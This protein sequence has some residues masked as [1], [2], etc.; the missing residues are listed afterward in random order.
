MR[1]P[2]PPPTDTLSG[3]AAIAPQTSHIPSLL[4]AWAA[5]LLA[6]DL[7]SIIGSLAGFDPPS[8][9]ALARAAAIGILALAIPRTSRLLHARGFIFALAALA[10]GGWAVAAVQQNVAWFA[11][12]PRA[13]AMFARL[14]L[15]LIPTALVAL[16]LIR[17]G[18]SRRD[19]FL[20]RG[21]LRAPTALPLIRGARWSLL[22]PALLLVVSAGLITQLWIVSHASRHLHP[23]A[24]LWALPS[25]LLFAIV[26]ASWEEF[27]FRCVLLARGLRAFSPNHAIAASSLLFGLA[28]YGG[29]PSGFSGVA[30]SAFF[31][32]I[33]AR[34]IVDTNGWTWA[35]L[36]HAI[37]DVIIFS[38]VSMTGV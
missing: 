15:Y 5:I 21:D 10:A 12:A 23:V 22:A 31:A 11:S 3:E 8:W 24:L 32:W 4:A 6:S 1:S 13:A 16:T 29:H 33:L 17:S 35:W 28:H 38:M 18:S 14:F 2:S 25:A 19:L 36:L 34:S 20:T 26:N 27:C 9:S 7:D 30:M 37:Q